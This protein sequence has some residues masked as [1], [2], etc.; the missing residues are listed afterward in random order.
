MFF[1]SLEMSAVELSM[2]AVANRA[3]I[4]SQQLRT[5]YDDSRVT[6]VMD[7]VGWY[8]DLS[9]AIDERASGTAADVCYAARRQYPAP[10]LVIV[11][12]LQLHTRTWLS[13]HMRSLSD[14]GK[15]PVSQPRSKLIDVIPDDVI[16]L[17]SVE[18]DFLNHIM[19]T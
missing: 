7:A 8:G 6:K 13:S 3:Q 2:R 1:A 19:T 4:D 5:A 11:D 16:E 17:P 12:H 18:V 14:R 9:I 10:D 15:Y